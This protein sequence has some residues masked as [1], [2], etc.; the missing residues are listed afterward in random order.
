MRSNPS[1]FSAENT[2]LDPARLIYRGNPHVDKYLS[3]LQQHYLLYYE[4]EP[5][6]ST[7]RSLNF[8]LGFVKQR[9]N[10]VKLTVE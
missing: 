9:V 1:F 6:C 7:V 2:G 3:L 5:H 10:K 4:L 8:T